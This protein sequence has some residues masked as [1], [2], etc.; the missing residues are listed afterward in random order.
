MAGHVLGGGSHW[1]LRLVHHQAHLGP[2][3][4]GVQVHPPVDESGRQVTATG[5][6][7]EV[8]LLDGLP[9]PEIGQSEELEAAY[10]F[11]HYL[12]DSFTKVQKCIDK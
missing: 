4:Q 12:R 9:R 6:G 7:E 8:M 11:C 1:D 10:L 2:L 5:L 3:A